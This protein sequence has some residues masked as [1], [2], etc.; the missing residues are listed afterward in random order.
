MAQGYSQ[1]SNLRPRFAG[2]EKSEAGGLNHTTWRKQ[3][4][5]QGRWTSPDPYLGS[6]SLGDPQS[7]NRYAYVQNDPVNFVDP[8]GLLLA[9]PIYHCIDGF[10]RVTGYNFID[11]GGGPSS[12]GPSVQ[13]EPGGGG[14]R[15]PKPE[16]KEEKK[17]CDVQ[18]PDDEQ[19][20]A[21]I[22]TILGEATSASDIGGRE[23]RDGDA[24]DSPSGD[25]ITS[26]TIEN[27]AYLMMSVVVNR[28][29]TN[30]NY[31]SWKDVVSDPGQFLGYND[32]QNLNAANFGNNGD[33][34]C[35][36]LR[37][38]VNAHNRASDGVKNDK[39][40]SW[41]GVKQDRRNGKG[42]FIR[43]QGNAIRAGRTDFF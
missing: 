1:P 6:M 28:F 13:P 31:H 34:S 8:S 19:S 18:I 30:K 14:R 36:R 10:C 40:R 2:T 3:D 24:V 32:G 25:I 17:P 12:G 35:E 37:S 15:Q 16:Q 27:E 22:G 26:S 21:V 4:T 9:I 39:L 38:I 33:P 11:I 29:R 5:L 23:Y 7:L 20:R 41:R 43:N 42:S